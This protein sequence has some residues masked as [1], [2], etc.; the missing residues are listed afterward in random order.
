M[1]GDHAMKMRLL[2]QIPGM[3]LAV[4]LMLVVAQG[5]VFGPEAHA[6]DGRG[7][8]GTWLNEVKIVTCPP[9][10]PAVLSTFQNMITYMR[11]GVLIIGGTPATPAVS[12]SVAHGIWERTGQ[13]TFRMFHRLHSFDGLGRFVRIA[14]VTNHLRLIKGD[15]PETDD[16]IEPYYLSAE[17]T[18]RITNLNPVDGSVIN[19]IEGC[20]EATQRPVLFED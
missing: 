18:N 12:N 20:N 9:V 1:K 3:T 4:M 19:V 5:L 17:G 11:G 14:E 2:T 7:L 16:V 10:P 15:D 8:E 13:R 6:G